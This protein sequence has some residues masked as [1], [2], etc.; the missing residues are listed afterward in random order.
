MPRPPVLPTIDWPTVWTFATG[1]E[2]WLDRAESAEKVARINENLAAQTLEPPVQAYVQN[3][4]R[5]VRVLAFAEDW[6]GDVVRHVPVLQALADAS[7]MV[8]VRYATREQHPDVFVRFLTN[9]GEAVPKFVFLSEDYVECGH[10]GPMP[11]RC[12]RLI[13]RGKACGDVGAARK[14]VAALYAAD[15]ERH[16]VVRELVDLLGIAAAEAP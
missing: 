11:E 12:R 15:P 9:G 5:L 7:G 3:L 6:C 4:P 2:D 1:Y 13:A 16:E 14:K 10:W 8:H